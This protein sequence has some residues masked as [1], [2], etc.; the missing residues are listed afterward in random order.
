L[1]FLTIAGI[2]ALLLIAGCVSPPSEVPSNQTTP[3]AQQSNCHM[4]SQQ[5]PVTKEECGPVQFTEQV[6]GIRKLNYTATELPKVDLCIADGPCSGNP[7]STCQICSKAMTR[8]VLVIKNEEETAAGT[9]TV[10]ANYTLGSNG[11]NKDPISK[12]IAPG[13]SFAFDFNQ[14]YGVSKP[15]T[16]ASCKLV[17]TA[18]PTVNDCHGETRSRSECTN[19]TTY[20]EVQKEVCE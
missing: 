15:I 10:A 1:R 16:T 12:T 6:C 3:P 7:I 11:F 9:W 19:V 4:E 8:C 18:E 20:E 17:V 13:E 2:F 5:V 14:F